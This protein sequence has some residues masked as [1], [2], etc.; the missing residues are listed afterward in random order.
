MAGGV[1]DAARDLR[2]DAPGV[3]ALPLVRAAA[4]AAFEE[5]YRA[6]FRDLSGYCAAL[7]GD[8]QLG[9]DCAQEAF[10]RLFSR[11]RSVR[12]PRSWL[13]LVATNVVRDEWRKRSR[14]RAAAQSLAICGAT[15]VEPVDP[16]LRDAIARL[17]R[18][19]AEVVLLHYFADLSLEDVARQIR[20]PLGTV[21][22]RLHEARARLQDAIGEA[23]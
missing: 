4:P 18:A 9:S 5:V 15:T 20:R 23:R 13:F 6:H 10:T 14:L 12:E 21:K 2:V 1:V 22:R 17:P 16:G 8:D 19:H 3:V 11:F 7:L